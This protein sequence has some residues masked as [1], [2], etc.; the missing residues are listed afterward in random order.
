MFTPAQ[1]PPA[2]CLVLTADEALLDDVL[3]LAAAAG[4]EVDV[5]ADVG[6]ARSRWPGAPLVVVGDDRAE[7]VSRQLGRRH[8]VVLVGP[9]VA[10]ADVWRRGV[11]IGAEQVIFLPDSEQWLV[12]RFA[13]AAEGRGR[14]AVV[15]GVVGGC[16]G[17]GASVLAAGLALTS[18]RRGLTTMLADLDPLG[19]GLDLLLGAEE[20]SGLRWPEFAETR[21]RL[22]AA[23]LCEAL[24]TCHGLTVLSWDRSNLLTVPAEAVHAVV[25]AAQ[26]GC[27]FVV[28]DLAR[29]MDAATE[30]AI[31]LCTCGLL[32]VP[33]RVRSVAAAGRVAVALTTALPDARVV[34]RGPAPSGLGAA[35]VADALG[36]PV[37][38]EMD[39][40]TG[41]DERLERGE[42]PGRTGRGPLA[43]ACEELLDDLVSQTQ[44][45]AA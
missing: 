44:V 6:A 5:A 38:A 18:A 33:A 34:V 30:E 37:A 14:D 20:S 11:A 41:L 39:A 24:P 27:D 16:G 7:E 10:D 2:R 8:D 17:A 45:W 15:V 12:E 35:D 42:P 26:R 9:D 36:L 43:R 19:G 40:E 21:G 29:R 13:D 22:A 25:T 31:S 3:R 32:V 4:V 28:L 1:P 23:A